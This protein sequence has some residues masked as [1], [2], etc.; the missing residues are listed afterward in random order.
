[1]QGEGNDFCCAEVKTKGVQRNFC[2]P[3]LERLYR[4]EIFGKLH[5]NKSRGKRYE[6]VT[7]MGCKENICHREDGQIL[8]QESREVIVA[9]SWETSKGRTDGALSTP[10]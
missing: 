10:V 9:P 6:L 1:M 4:K 7:L 8:Q 2:L 5:G 3:L